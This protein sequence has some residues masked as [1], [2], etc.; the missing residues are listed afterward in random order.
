V[1]AAQANTA[2]ARENLARESILTQFQSVTAPFSGIVTARN[3][4]N[5][6]LINAGGASGSAVSSGSSS[7]GVTT[8]GTAAS[9]GT[10]AGS[11]TSTGAASGSV[12][13]IAQLD[14]VRIYVNVPQEDIGSLHPGIP[15][16]ISVREL[17]SK[18]FSGTIVRTADALDPSSRTLV[19]EV[20][21]DN[22]NGVLRPGMFASVS[23]SVDQPKGLLII[24]DSAMIS[25]GSGT[26][27]ALVTQ[28]K[29]VHLANISVGRDF[30][31][32]M[33]VLSGISR[34]DNIIDNP[35]DGLKEGQ[36]VS[37]SPE[38]VKKSPS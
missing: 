14:R 27:V 15:A 26:Q 18:K 22:P 17:P 21:I 13:S 34:E 4:D 36:K 5:G 19:A 10:S 37:A 28:N 31:T 38:K 8:T 6:N 12:F 1:V 16:S 32:T 2:S 30:G 3:V 20:D 25:N 29:T 35:P 11:G 9:G 7:A 33:Q 23:F 24:P